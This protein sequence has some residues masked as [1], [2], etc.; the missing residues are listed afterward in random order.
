MAAS[1]DWKVYRDKE[2]VASCKYPEDAAA[3]VAAMSGSVRYTHA[4]EV[5]AQ[6]DENQALAA[7]SYDEAADIMRANRDRVQRENFEKVYGKRAAIL[8]HRR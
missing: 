8:A 6:T 7:D 4:R 5:F 1:P 2:Y 3:I